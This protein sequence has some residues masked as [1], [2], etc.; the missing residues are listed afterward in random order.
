[1]RGQARRW[2]CAP[3]L[4][5]ACAACDDGEPGQGQPPSAP[6]P[7]VAPAVPAR[8][9]APVHEAELR[10][11]SAAAP[12]TRPAWMPEGITLL[13]TTTNAFLVPLGDV[14]LVVTSTWSEAGASRTSA[15]R[16]AA[17]GGR[18][19]LDGVHAG[20]LVLEARAAGHLPARLA[21]GRI[22][23]GDVRDELRVVLRGA[24]ALEVRTVDA[25]GR[26]L[27]DACV[28][29]AEGRTVRASD[30]SGRVRFEGLPARPLQLQAWWGPEGATCL[31]SA[32]V[33]PGAVS[34]L[35]LVLRAGGELELRFADA[36][37]ARAALRDELGR[38]AWA[39]ELGPREECGA[40]PWWPSRSRTEAERCGAGSS[41]A[42][43]GSR[44]RTARPAAPPGA[45]SRCGRRSARG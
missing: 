13:G 14:E 17:R 4:A 11:P 1:M 8:L 22:E 38:L 15:Q 9:A 24:H 39:F 37:E 45:R 29:L 6:Q 2:A 18:F 40:S 19:E 42:A 32:R 31:A 7:S 20:E 43:S 44:P 5:L 3:W 35:E 34:E 21:L 41:R 27:A 26:P 16:G 10:A 23:A 28:R 30:A 12:R 25:L 36:P 33:E